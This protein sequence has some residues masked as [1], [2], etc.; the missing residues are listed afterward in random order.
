MSVNT[1]EILWTLLAAV[2]AT[3]VV[4]IVATISW[5]RGLQRAILET[6]S[7]SE[8]HRLRVER[9]RLNCSAHVIYTQCIAGQL[10]PSEAESKLASIFLDTREVAGPEHGYY[11]WQGDD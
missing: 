11:I 2:F 9:H 4:S 3:G 10:T 7:L 5:H 1:A 8:A 6:Q